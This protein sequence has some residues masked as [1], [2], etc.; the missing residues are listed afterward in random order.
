MKELI[1]EWRKF[2]AEGEGLPRHI[3]FPEETYNNLV[4]MFLRDPKDYFNKNGMGRII[5]AMNSVKR[6][7]T[8]GNEKVSVAQIKKAIAEAEKIL[9]DFMEI[10]KAS[11][12]RRPN[13]LF[14]QD[15]IKQLFKK[16]VEIKTGKDRLSFIKTDSL[17]NFLW[18]KYIRHDYNLRYGV[19]TKYDKDKIEEESAGSKEIV[20]SLKKYNL[21]TI[22]QMEESLREPII[23]MLSS[24]DLDNVLQAGY[25]IF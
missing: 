22:N 16:L 12:M 17:F 23:K 1:T 13:D 9:N 25:L 18:D 5:T 4:L 3:I 24:L 8:E 15:E 19:E 2:L 10:Y 21:E 11:G 7:K 20:D 14:I 6:K